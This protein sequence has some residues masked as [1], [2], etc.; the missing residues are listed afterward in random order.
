MTKRGHSGIRGRCQALPGPVATTPGC[1][2]RRTRPAAPPRREGRGSR[3]IAAGTVGVHREAVC[4]ETI[5][6]G[7]GCSARNDEVALST[8]LDATRARSRQHEHH[9]A[10]QVGHHRQQRVATVRGRRTASRRC[11]NEHAT[12]TRRRNFVVERCDIEVATQ[13]FRMPSTLLQN[14]CDAA[15]DAARAPSRSAND[16]LGAAE[17]VPPVAMG[18]ELGPEHPEEGARAARRCRV[19]WS[20]R[21]AWYSGTFEIARRRHS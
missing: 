14:H 6:T 11:S 12:W 3:D 1:Q 21:K 20:S 16:T 17:L 8:G 7:R 2:R 18:Q 13:T 10:R 4:S 15:R 5:N 19:S 9:Q